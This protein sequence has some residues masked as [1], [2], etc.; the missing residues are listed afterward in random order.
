ML[1]MK[2]RI[3]TIIILAIFF[4]GPVS[5]QEKNKRKV[6]LTG[7]IVTGDTVPISNVMI[8]LDGMN[9]NKMSNGNGEFR[10]KFKPDIKKISFF[11]AKYGGFE[12]DYVGQER[13]EVMIN[14]ESNELTINPFS[15]GEV[16]ETGYGTIRK[17]E[18]VGSISSIESD[19]FENR[20]YKDVYEMIAGE[21]SG[22]V[23]EGTAIRIR[24]ITSL[25]ASN[26]PLLI[27]DGAPVYSLSHISPA[28]VESIYILK[29]S[30]TAI[31]G[32]RGA[33]GVVVITTKTGRKK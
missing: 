4:C 29:G 31:Y 20:S 27:V 24:G 28:D 23:V 8:F 26:D 25:N 9:T 6:I 7:R 10:V 17:D 18:L 11:S 2:I 14:I 19:R 22:V 33:A 32:T 3:A 30:S 13:L 12:V 15:V 1:I 21:V 5:S 16:V